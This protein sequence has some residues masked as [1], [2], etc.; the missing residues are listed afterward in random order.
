VNLILVLS[1]AHQIDT[2]DTV[3][4]QTLN[5]EQEESITIDKQD[6][7][8]LNLKAGPRAIETYKGV[9]VEQQTF[10]IRQNHLL[11][12]VPYMVILKRG[13]HPKIVKVA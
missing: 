11:G 7:N 2:L 13:K 4:A 3:R 6:N 5:T 12:N 10:A 9:F 8:R 1:S